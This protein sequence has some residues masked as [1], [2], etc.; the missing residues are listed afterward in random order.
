LRSKK[1]TI[2]A[3]LLLLFVEVIDDNSDKQVKSEEGAKDDEED[4]V[5]IHVDIR[6]SNGLLL[7]L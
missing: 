2:S 6:F 4:E 1:Q 7:K 3:Y 5:Q